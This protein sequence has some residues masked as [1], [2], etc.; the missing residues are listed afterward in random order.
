[1]GL[2][3]QYIPNRLCIYGGMRYF[4][5]NKKEVGYLLVAN[6]HFFRASMKLENFGNLS[7]VEN[8]RNHFRVSPK[9]ILRKNFPE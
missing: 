3:D 2:K 5:V 7:A 8:R 1:M 6:L 9:H 4:F